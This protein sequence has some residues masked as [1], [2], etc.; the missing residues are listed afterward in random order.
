MRTHPYNNYIRARQVA[1]VEQ[2]VSNT[3]TL[4]HIGVSNPP[5]PHSYPPH[6]SSVSRTLALTR[7]FVNVPPPAQ[8]VKR[9]RGSFKPY[10]E[11]GWVWVDIILV[12]AFNG[13]V[14]FKILF[15]VDPRRIAADV[16]NPAHSPYGDLAF[17]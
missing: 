11:S 1:V 16:T 14:A 15:L 9:V 7:T 5:F 4:A 3:P 13:C 8:Y 2:Y 10:F 6:L 12:L 17:W